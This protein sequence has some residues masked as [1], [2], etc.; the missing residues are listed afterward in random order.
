MIRYLININIYSGNHKSTQLQ[1][2]A[3]TWRLISGWF[4][5]SPLVIVVVT[6][7]SPD[8]SPWSRLPTW[9]VGHEQQCWITI[10]MLLTASVASQH[11]NI[12]QT[13][14]YYILL[15]CNNYLC[16]LCNIINNKITNWFTIHCKIIYFQK[17]EFSNIYVFG[18]C[19]HTTINMNNN[20]NIN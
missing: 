15:I 11:I 1:W 5:N 13:I 3:L 18:G 7:T 20:N 6:T 17:L 10:G 9:G 16:R 19:A 2:M 4:V 8:N 14:N 12:N